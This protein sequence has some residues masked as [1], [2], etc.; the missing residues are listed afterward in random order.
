MGTG[1]SVLTV[2]GADE[3]EEFGPTLEERFK[4]T[5]PTLREYQNERSGPRRRRVHAGRYASELPPHVSTEECLEA[6]HLG[7]ELQSALY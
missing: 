3:A 2:Q 5:I 7:E 1:P 6:L 4:V